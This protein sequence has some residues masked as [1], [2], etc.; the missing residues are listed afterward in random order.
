MLKKSVEILISVLAV[1][2]FS[3][4]AAAEKIIWHPPKDGVVRDGETAIIIA[5]AIWA[6]MNHDTQISS[7]KIWEEQATSSLKDGIWL[8]QP[9]PFKNG[10]LGGGLHISISKRDGRIVGMYITQ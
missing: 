2:L 5:H 4:A 10:E 7:E 6:S 8:V 3:Q 9:K 1:A